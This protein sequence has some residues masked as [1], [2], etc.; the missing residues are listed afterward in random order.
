MKKTNKGILISVEGI[1]GA[2]K[3][4][5]IKLLH[6]RMVTEK[7]DVLLTK[8][9][10]SSMLGKYLRQLLHA[11]QMPICTKAEYL[12]FAADRAQHMND[13]VLPALEKGAIV[14]SDRMA[15]SSLA[16][17]GYARGLDIEFIQYV[18][19]WTMD[20]CEPDLIIFVD[21]PVLLAIERI[22]K[23]G[24]I[25]TFEKETDFLEKVRTG[26][27]EIFS[28]KN[29]VITVDGTLTPDALLATTYKT[30]SSFLTSRWA[31]GV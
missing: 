7:L 24:N 4:T 13:F 12:L 27:L 26:F 14:L 11:Q 6:Q 2:G 23:R 20:Q 21:T 31:Q 9:P 3:S 18:N 15:D 25:N 29:N 28:S 17:Q 30:V 1:D 22:N 16:Y 8:E 19:R 10:G 5:L